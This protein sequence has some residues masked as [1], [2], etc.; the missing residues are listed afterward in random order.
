MVDRE[1]LERALRGTLR[2]AGRRYERLRRAYRDG[3]REVGSGKANGDG[4]GAA[5]AV[6][7]D[8]D[9]DRIPS[10]IPRNPA[11]RPRLVCR[12]H[13]E[14]RAVDLDDRDRPTCFEPGHP[15]CEGCVE[16]LHA[17]TIETW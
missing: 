4:Q 13:A 1:R 8:G 3:E 11:G 2:Q 14:R 6:D 5:A 17:G 9:R 15:D 12:R 7:H 10:S 16:D